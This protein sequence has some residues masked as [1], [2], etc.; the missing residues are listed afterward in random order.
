MDKEELDSALKHL[1]NDPNI[2]S[3]IIKYNRP[4]FPLSGS[5]FKSL[6]KYII[7]QQ[8]SLSSAKAIYSRFLNLF[9][10]NYNDKSIYK[11]PDSRFKEIGISKQKTNYIKS[12]SKYFIDHNIDFQKLNNRQIYDKLIEIRGVGPWTIDMFLMFTLYRT[13]VLPI[14]DLGIK[15]GFKILYGLNEL[16]SDKFMLIKSKKWSPY[17]T[18][19]S[20]YIWKIVDG[21][22]VF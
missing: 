6:I 13:D 3:L 7:Y 12:I 2:K 14:G 19:A 10:K 8:L 9:D 4:H 11:T 17:K 20:M 22:V 15:K 1:A 5:P 21:D 18:I 16:P